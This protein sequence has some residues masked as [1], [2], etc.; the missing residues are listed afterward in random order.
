MNLVFIS[1]IALTVV[2]R[3][4]CGFSWLMFFS[5]IG[6]IIFLTRI[7]GAVVNYKVSLT[8]EGIHLAF[9]LLGLIMNGI[10]QDWITMLI[11]V[12]MCLAVA[13]LVWIDNTFYLYVVEDDDEVED[14]EE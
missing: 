14:G 11:D 3:I 6:R 1:I 12:G 8:F 13:A 2:Q 4:L 9:V 7:I 10:P 5:Y